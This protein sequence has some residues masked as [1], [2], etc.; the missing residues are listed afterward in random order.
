MCHLLGERRSASAVGP[1]QYKHTASVNLASVVTSKTVTS[2]MRAASFAATCACVAR[3]RTSCASSAVEVSVSIMAADVSYLQHGNEYKQFKSG[4]YQSMH[5]DIMY[6]WRG[7]MSMVYC[8]ERYL[9]VCQLS[10]SFMLER[11]NIC[12]NLMTSLAVT[13]CSA[14]RE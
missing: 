5:S 13:S 4:K 3:S 7:N 8:V 12:H 14:R 11:A 6:L 2:A 10:W 1:M 9:Y